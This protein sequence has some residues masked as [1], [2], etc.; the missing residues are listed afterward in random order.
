[1]SKHGS[2]QT[3]ITQ[4]H[5]TSCEVYLLVNTTVRYTFDTITSR[6]RHIQ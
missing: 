2:K 5:A 1:M 6:F 4:N 3:E